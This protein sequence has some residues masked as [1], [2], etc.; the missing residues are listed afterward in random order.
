MSNYLKIKNDE[1]RL[2]RSMARIMS[3][4]LPY[5]TRAPIVLE[6]SHRISEL[7]V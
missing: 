4:N 5:K 1:Q 3:V 2:L 7:I 6:R